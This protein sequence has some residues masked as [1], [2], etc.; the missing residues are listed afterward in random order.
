MSSPKYIFEPTSRQLHI[1]QTYLDA[2]AEKKK[3]MKAI[4]ESHHKECVKFRH[5]V[6]MHTGALKALKD[7]KFPGRR[8]SL[9]KQESRY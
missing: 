1:R 4:M 5:A 6:I 9:T 2:C 7:C 3:A 8:Y